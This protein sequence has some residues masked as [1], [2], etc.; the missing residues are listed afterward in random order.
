MDL[1]FENINV[2]NLFFVDDN[3]SN[4]HTSDSVTRN[5]E[6]NLTTTTTTTATIPDDGEEL[7]S[8]DEPRCIDNMINF[9][10]QYCNQKLSNK[11]NQNF[12]QRRCSSFLNQIGAGNKNNIMMGRRQ[13]NMMTNDTIGDIKLVQSSMNATDKYNPLSAS[14]R[15]TLPKSFSMKKALLTLPIEIKDVLYQ[16]NDSFIQSHQPLKETPIKDPLEEEMERQSSRIIFSSSP[17]IN[18]TDR[19]NMEKYQ[20]HS[21]QVL[22][23]NSERLKLEDYQSKRELPNGLIPKITA[24]RD[25]STTNK[26]KWDQII[27]S[28][29]N[30]LQKLLIA[31]YS[32]SV[33]KHKSAIAEI[34]LNLN[35]GLQRTALQKAKQQFDGREERI[36]Q[37]YQQQQQQQQPQNQQ[38]PQHQPNIFTPKRKH[39]NDN[40]SNSATMAA[41]MDKTNANEIGKAVEAVLVAAPDRSGGG[42]GT[43][44]LI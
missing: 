41:L 36:Q 4:I 22:V 29:G 18:S 42:G 13:Q 9:S 37:R 39:Q 15:T 14:A 34:K 19:I 21:Y 44:D 6:N 16:F 10:G 43:N 11:A 31:H 35:E 7:T 17:V 20:N 1:N 23:S 40:Y 30:Q 27:K 2:E 3:S 12:H 26:T 38:Q 25:L 5:D 24:T 33:N 8:P 32:E 28:T